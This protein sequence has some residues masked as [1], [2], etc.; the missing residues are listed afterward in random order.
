MGLWQPIKEGLKMKTQ[1]RLAS[2]AEGLYFLSHRREKSLFTNI[3][4]GGML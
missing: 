3:N 1:N 4:K 2:I